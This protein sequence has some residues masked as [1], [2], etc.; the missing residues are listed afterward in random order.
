MNNKIMIL[1]QKKKKKKKKTFQ[2]DSLLK[3]LRSVC[4]EVLH[5][6]VVSC[7]STIWR[8]VFC[9]CGLSWIHLNLLIGISY[10]CS[11]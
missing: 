3:G 10:K 11:P 6:V 7:Y 1:P 9:V 5:C 4:G 2:G 8:A